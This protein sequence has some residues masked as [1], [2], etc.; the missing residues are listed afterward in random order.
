MHEIVETDMFIRAARL[1]GVS[2]NERMAII[3]RIA[4]APDAGDLIQGT[5]GARK[6]RVAARGKGKSGGYRVIHYF[7][8]GNIPVYLLTIYGKGDR[9]DLSADMRKAIAALI[10]QVKRD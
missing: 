10:E 4:A 2:D 7:G 9:A 8:G 6:V 5:G 1:T 3:D